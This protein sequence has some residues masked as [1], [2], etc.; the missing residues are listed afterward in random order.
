MNHTYL[1]C[2]KPSYDP[3]IH[4]AIVITE[5]SMI[6]EHLDYWAGGDDTPK[7]R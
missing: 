4:L 1:R 6:V 2:Y 5:N 3:S 7:D